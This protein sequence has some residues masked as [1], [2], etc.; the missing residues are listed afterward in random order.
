MAPRSSKNI[1]DSLTE[2][3][4]YEELANREVCKEIRSLNSL[5]AHLIFRPS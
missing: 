1:E 5:E 2:S 3:V 4:K